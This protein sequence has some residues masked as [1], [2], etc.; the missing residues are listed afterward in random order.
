MHPAA[1]RGLREL[2]VMTRQLRDHWRTLATRLD[3]TA[4]DQARLLREG[5]NVARTLLGA[6]TD[7]TAA[8]GIYGRPAAEGFGARLAAVHS[9]LLDTAL[10]VNQALRFAVFDVVH[11]VT[12]LDL[13]ARVAA[14]DA[15][16][17]LQAFLEGWSVRMRAQEDAVRAAAIA[18]GDAPD[19]AVQAS[20]PGLAGRIGH[21]AATAI[22]T[23]GEWV[24]GRCGR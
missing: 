16:P 24:D 21:G 11:V 5:S 18:L 20:T 17:E 19:L 12:L 22:G 14:Q 9:V 13:L 10:E 15:D 6:L 7:E 4:A 3:A 8:R 1:H 2:Y 23:V